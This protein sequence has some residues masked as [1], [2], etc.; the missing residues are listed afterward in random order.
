MTTAVKSVSAGTR[1]SLAKVSH[2]PEVTLYIW[3]RMGETCVDSV[4]RPFQV[5]VTMSV[6]FKFLYLYS[7]IIYSEPYSIK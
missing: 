3:M 7:R 1:V 5:N 4:E 6:L 2:V